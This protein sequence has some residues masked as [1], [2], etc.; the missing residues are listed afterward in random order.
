MTSP[1]TALAK[2]CDKWWVRHSRLHEELRKVKGLCNRDYMLPALAKDR[3][4]FRAT[5]MPAAQALRVLRE[6]LT[7]GAWTQLRRPRSPF[8]AVG[9]TCRE[10]FWALHCPRRA[11]VQTKL[12]TGHALNFPC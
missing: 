12:A 8:P 2:D 11:S 5:P 7:T 4:G 1:D 10:S 9:Y 6:G 3:R